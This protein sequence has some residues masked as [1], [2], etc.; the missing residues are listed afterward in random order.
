[1]VRVKPYINFRIISASLVLFC[2]VL[3]GCGWGSAKSRYILAENLWNEGKYAASVAEFERVA[4]R[5]NRGKLGLQALFRAAMTQT[6]FLNR[7]DD[8][9]RKFKNYIDFSSDQNSTWEAQKQIGEIYFLRT[10]QYEQALLHYRAILKLKPD[11][12]EAPE[13]YYRIGRSQFFLWQFEEAT[14][15]YTELEKKYPNT[16]WAERALLERGMTHYTQGSQNSGSR[17]KALDAFKE[18]RNT[19]SELIKK[20]PQSTLVPEAQFGIANCLEEV[21]QL[22][23]ASQIYQAIAASYPSPKVIKIKLQRIKERQ[24]QKKR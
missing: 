7:H 18:A 23:A 6:L 20:Y 11:A 14:Q 19:F 2:L 1:M 21:D 13:F 4:A 5:D 12:P 15:T 9:V 17:E 8:A 16:K 10:E 24:A 3:A 22:D